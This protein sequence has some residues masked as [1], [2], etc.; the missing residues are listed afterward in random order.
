LQVAPEDSWYWIAAIP[1][2]KTGEM[3]PVCG[4]NADM[5]ISGWDEQGSV[6]VAAQFI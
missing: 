2:P 6:V 4:V 3:E 5:N 1:D